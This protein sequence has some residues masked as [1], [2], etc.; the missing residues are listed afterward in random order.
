LVVAGFGILGS[1]SRASII[2]STFPITV[3]ADLDT[4]LAGLPPGPDYERTVGP[5]VSVLGERFS[6][7]SRLYAQEPDLGFVS[8]LSPKQGLI[9]ACLY[10]RHHD[11]FVRERHLEAVRGSEAWLP[12][13]TLQLISEYVIE[14]CKSALD[15]ID[16]IPRDVYR[17]FADENPE[18]MRVIR[19]RVVSYSRSYPVTFV[20]Y[21]GYMFLRDLGLWEGREAARWI[22][23]AG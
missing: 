10:T 21:P 6:L 11:G 20:E 17:A 16:A 13:F 23:A 2:R 19:N 7:L 3:R 14:I 9:L 12:I 8:Q 18:F 15:R 4:V 22:R 5:E 1:V